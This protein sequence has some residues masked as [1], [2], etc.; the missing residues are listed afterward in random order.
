MNEFESMSTPD[1]NAVIITQYNCRWCDKVKELLR[2]HDY[3]L[4]IINWKMYPAA[5]EYL[6]EHKLTTVPQVFIKGQHI[7]G[8]E[9]TEEYLNK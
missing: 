7:G 8:Y 3:H 4:I 9:A 6:N 5:K 2:E 1:G